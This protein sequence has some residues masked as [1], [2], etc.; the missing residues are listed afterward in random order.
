MPCSH[1]VSDL[2]VGR[3]SFDRVPALQETWSEITIAKFEGM[4]KAVLPIQNAIGLNQLRFSITLL[5]TVFLLHSTLH[6]SRSSAPCT[7][8]H[9]LPSSI[10]PL[11]MVLDPIMLSNMPK[12]LHLYLNTIGCC[13][14]VVKVLRYLSGYESS[15]WERKNFKAFESVPYMKDQ[16]PKSVRDV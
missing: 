16:A 10:R 3:G 1:R 5:P 14:I 15:R 13:A 12:R 2:R 4:K 6:P 7:S 9:Y 11:H 8:L